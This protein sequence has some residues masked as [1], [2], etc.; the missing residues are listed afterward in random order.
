VNSQS[1]L[2]AS[3]NVDVRSYLEIALHCYGFR[4]ET[5][6]DL[7]QARQSVRNWGPVPAILLDISKRDTLPVLLT[8][9][10]IQR[11]LSV[12]VLSPNVSSGM[13]KDAQRAGGSDFL[14][15]FT[16]AIAQHRHRFRRRC[17]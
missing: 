10:R 1:V 7:H 14:T 2:V 11:N 15:R 5:I 16:R 8:L 6:E 13:V 4:V 9:C 17:R 12:M 3:A